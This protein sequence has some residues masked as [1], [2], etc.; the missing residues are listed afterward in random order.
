MNETTIAEFIG[1]SE[2]A[3][4]KI[5]QKYA[6]DVLHLG[7]RVFHDEN[8]ATEF[9]QEFMTHVWERHDKFIGVNNFNAFLW[10]MA[11]NFAFDKQRRI[12]TQQQMLERFRRE[13]DKPVHNDVDQQ[14]AKSDINTIIERALAS[15]TPRRKE[16]FKLSREQGLSPAEIA[17]RLSLAKQTVN[18]EMVQVLKTIRLYL[19]SNAITMVVLTVCLWFM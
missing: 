2:R 9:L 14:F 7:R 1:G 6:P 3:F 11:W 17:E 16:I 19:Q 13:S 15:T 12:I 4:N 8:L 5:Y 10:R 18:N